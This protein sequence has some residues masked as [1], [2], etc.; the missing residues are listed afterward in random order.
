VART[1]AALGAAAN[2]EP[3]H[4][5]EALSYRMPADLPSA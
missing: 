3:R 4:I 2:V 5:A 1:I